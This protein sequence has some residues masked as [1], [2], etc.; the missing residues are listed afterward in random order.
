MII[1]CKANTS[2]A[3][4]KEYFVAF[5]GDSDQSTYHI[6]IGRE[7]RVFAMALWHSQLM[8]LLC[9]DTEYPIWYSVH[10]FSIRD[11]SLPGN[12]QCS[13]NMKNEGGLQAIWGYERLVT[14]KFHHDALMER[15]AEALAFFFDER[16]RELGGWSRD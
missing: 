7:Y 16:R 12:W 6:S 2:N 14:D 4:P 13:I 11:T 10:F 8:V 1:V 5:P 15:D 3:L 9:D